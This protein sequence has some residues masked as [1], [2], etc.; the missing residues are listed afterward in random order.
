MKEKIF[1]N[2]PHTM[3]IEW[4]LYAK[5]LTFVQV[6][7]RNDLSGC[8][9]SLW[10]ARSSSE[11][12]KPQHRLHT[13]NAFSYNQRNNKWTFCSPLM[14]TNF[15]RG[16]SQILYVPCHNL[17]PKARAAESP[18]IYSYLYFSPAIKVQSICLIFYRIV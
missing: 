6:L 4:N 18:L 14:C 10:L 13:C 12:N 8:S 15:T 5:K 3:S 1:I 2:I 16:I 7:H 9:M 17:G 11:R